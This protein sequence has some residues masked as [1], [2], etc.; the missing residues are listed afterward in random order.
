MLRAWGSWE[1]FQELLAELKSVARKHRSS[2]AHV[3]LRWV[4]DRPAVGS[5]LVGARLGYVDHLQENKAVLKLRL[6]DADREN[7]ARA[8][9]IGRDLTEVLGG[10]GV[11]YQR[12]V[13]DVPE[14]YASAVELRLRREA[15]NRQRGGG[16][17]GQGEGEGGR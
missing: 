3:A 4:L 12:A 17:Q 13:A 2:I 6:T 10:V 7:L 11:E 15:E 9:R 16:G 1:Q 8:A 5:V 14:R